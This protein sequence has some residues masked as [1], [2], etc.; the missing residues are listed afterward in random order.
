MTYSNTA[1]PHQLQTLIPT[2]SF[3]QALPFGI[4]EDIPFL[5]MRIKDEDE[6]ILD[7]G[8]LTC[9]FKPSIFNLDY[10][11]HTVALCIVQFRI[12][13]SDSHIYTTG[14]DL[15]NPKQYTLCQALLKMLDYGLLL[16]T[17]HVHTYKHFRAN[18]VG[19]F[20][21]IM[22]IKEARDL[23]TDYDTPLFT[24]VMQGLMIQKTSPAELWR[25]LEQIAPPQRRWYLQV[26]A[27]LDTITA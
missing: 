1:L 11:E 5:A 17:E 13:G 27:A 19:T 25:Y 18:F 20:N 14:Y 2:L 15:S 12:N 23:A 10:K 4:V 6:I 22:V 26:N 3:E 24:T 9:E 16:A 21:P 7:A 8:T